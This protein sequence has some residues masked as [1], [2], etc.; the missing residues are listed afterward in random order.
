MTLDP[1]GGWQTVRIIAAW[2]FNPDD[3]GSKVAKDLC[4]TTPPA[5]VSDREREDR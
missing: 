1:R 4:G 5:H 3:L 2:W